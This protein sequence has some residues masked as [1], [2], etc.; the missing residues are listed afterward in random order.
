MLLCC[1]QALAANKLSGGRRPG[2]LQAL[3]EAQ[4]RGAALPFLQ[5]LVAD[6][7]CEQVERRE[8]YQVSRQVVH[9]KLTFKETPGLGQP[10]VTSIPKGKPVQAGAGSS[11]G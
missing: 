6:T 9:P 5:G 11:S 7:A 1:L 4:V 10:R 2:L 8:G 3:R